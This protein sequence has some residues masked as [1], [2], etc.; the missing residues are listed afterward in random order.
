MSGRLGY[1]R[2]RPVFV[3]GVVG[4]LEVKAAFYF[5]GLVGELAISHL[6]GQ[7]VLFFCRTSRRR[8]RAV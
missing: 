1:E 5:S 7:F 6:Q 4:N 8:S 2:K 3:L